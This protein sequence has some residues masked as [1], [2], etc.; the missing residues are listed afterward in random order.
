MSETEMASVQAAKKALR[1]SVTDQLKQLSA[2]NI[3]GQ[4]RDNDNM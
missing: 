4:C 2:E 3:R 1:K